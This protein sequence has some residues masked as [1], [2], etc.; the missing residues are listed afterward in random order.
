MSYGGGVVLDPF[1]GSG[2]TGIVSVRNARKFIG[3]ELN[4]K[5]AEMSNN[6]IEKEKQQGIQQSLF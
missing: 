5:Y 6:R 1:C 4:P 3:I 2:T